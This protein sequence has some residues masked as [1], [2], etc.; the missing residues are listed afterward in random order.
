MNTT[1]THNKIKFVDAQ[2][3][4]LLY[5][6]TYEAPNTEDLR[7]AYPG[8]L[9]NVCANNENFW[10]KIISND[11]GLITGKINNN[12]L[13]NEL[14]INDEIEFPINCILQFYNR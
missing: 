10:V 9:V 6:E 13:Q 5:P 12:L 1:I 7:S 2:A 8:N 14:K 4:R 3:M 11:N